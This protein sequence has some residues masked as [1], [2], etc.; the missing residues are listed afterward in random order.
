M[1]PHQTLTIDVSKEVQLLWKVN[2]I[3]EA[4]KT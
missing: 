1:L 2:G 3:E 4:N